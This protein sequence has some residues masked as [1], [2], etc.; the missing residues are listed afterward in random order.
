MKIN[1]ILFGIM[2]LFFTLACARFDLPRIQEDKLNLP[3]IIIP[4]PTPPSIIAE[5]DNKKADDKDVNTHQAHSY[6]LRLEHQKATLTPGSSQPE[7]FNVLGQLQSIERI[8][9]DI[10]IENKKKENAKLEFEKNS[11]GQQS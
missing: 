5:K 2:F 8:K 1:Y 7:V 11:I 3:E 6:K 10:Q 4:T 9:K